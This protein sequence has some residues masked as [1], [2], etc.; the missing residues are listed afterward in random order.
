MTV[1]KP[2]G[3]FIYILLTVF[4]WYTNVIEPFFQ[5]G[6]IIEILGV[7]M[8]LS[9]V[10]DLGINTTYFINCLPKAFII[11]ILFFL[12]MLPWG[13]LTSSSSSVHVATWIRAVEYLFV[14]IMMMYYV[15]TR[16]NIDSVL[17]NFSLIS[18]V[19][20]CIFIMNPAD[21]GNGLG[22]YSL[23]EGTNPNGFAMTLTQGLWAILLLTSF[24]KI[25]KWFSILSCGLIF[26]SI[27]L[28]GS[29]KGLIGFSI[30]LCGWILCNSVFCFRRYVTVNQFISFIFVI[31]GIA[32]AASIIIPYYMNS[33][34]S[35]RMDNL[36][37]EASTGSRSR[38]YSLAFQD[39]KDNILTGYGFGGFIQRY[40][41]Y[42]HATYAEVPVSCGL[43]LS[44]FYFSSYITAFVEIIKTNRIC[45]TLEYGY[46]SR[47]IRMTQMSFV[48]LILLLFY[49]TCIIHI[50]EFASM[51]NFGLMFSAYSL[52]KQKK[53]P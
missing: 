43:G 41:V 8:L 16:N 32:L 37:S 44:L 10:F 1:Q 9:F 3:T 24:K 33:S 12:I 13:A 22:R 48:M 7:L 31:V 49:G 27:L 4:F 5:I 53:K 30:V 36:L 23:T 28:T 46:Q 52:A 39:F 45:K 6:H 20:C 35:G 17:W 29:R 47:E 25:P 18:I 40:G 50:Y 15:L 21:L 14:G 11:Q 51:I 42:T 34:I 38:L 26:Y 2:K 19:L